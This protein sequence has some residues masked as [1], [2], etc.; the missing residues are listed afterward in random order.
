MQR[1]DRL[2]G[3]RKR[4]ECDCDHSSTPWGASVAETGLPRARQSGRGE[5]I[6]IFPMAPGPLEARPERPFFSRAGGEPRSPGSTTLRLRPPPAVATCQRGR[7]RDRRGHAA[8]VRLALR[9]AHRS[10]ATSP[11]AGHRARGREMVRMTQPTAP[12]GACPGRAR[13]VQQGCCG[14]VGRPRPA[15]AGSA[16]ADSSCAGRDARPGNKRESGGSDACRKD[17]LEESVH[18]RSPGLADR[19]TP[20]TDGRGIARPQGAERAI[21]PRD[22]SSSRTPRPRSPPR[23][24]LCGS[25]SA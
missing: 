6:A 4:A 13:H 8:P 19:G 2:P 3:T 21:R 14:L 10:P 22:H 11:L 12:R 20:I 23:D 1:P 5:N 25:L 18:G 17:G 7:R 24:E 9:S 15:D 16:G